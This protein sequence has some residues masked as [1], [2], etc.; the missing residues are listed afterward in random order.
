[1][2]YVTFLPRFLYLYIC[3]PSNCGH[4]KFIYPPGHGS[5]S[6]FVDERCFL[7]GV[8]ASVFILPPSRTFC[9]EYYCSASTVNKIRT[10]LAICFVA[11]AYDHGFLLIAIVSKM[12]KVP[13]TYNSENIIDKIIVL[14]FHPLLFFF[15]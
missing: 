5:G 6:G 12:T 1:M 3:I 8:A 11:I 14:L 15:K 4:L 9:T 2:L 7:L 10:M 13:P